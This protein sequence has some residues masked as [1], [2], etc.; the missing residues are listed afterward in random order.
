MFQVH[1]I[2]NRDSVY[3]GTNDLGYMYLV[4]YLNG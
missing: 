3:F 1:C 2:T 4:Q